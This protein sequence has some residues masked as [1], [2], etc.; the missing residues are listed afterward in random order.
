MVTYYRFM[1]PELV[2]KAL[3]DPSRRELLDLLYLKDGQSLTDLESH[4]PMTRFG[5]MKHLRI[6][7]RAGLVVTRKNG[8]E[9]LHYLNAV[10]IQMVYDRWVSKYSKGWSRSLTELKYDLEAVD[11]AEAKTAETTTH[12]F[13]VYIKTTPEKLWEAITD[14]SMT[15]KY[16]YNSRVVSNW[17]NGSDYKYL[18]PDDS[19]LVEGRVVECDPLRRLVT[20]F[21]PT[22][23]PEAV[24]KFPESTVTYEIT[25]LGET[26]KLRLVH[27]GLT[28]G[29]PMTE[30]I[31]RGWSEILSGLKTLVETGQPLVITTANE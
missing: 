16:Y 20:S 14:G 12:V 13:E 1:E 25:Q 24:G 6:L 5:V 21:N 29:D 9:T 19:V 18:A 23:N 11:M 15:E 3:A 7:E 31:F 28:P 2:F 17:K 22:W 26:C 27:E 10:P 4:L 8:R 30:G